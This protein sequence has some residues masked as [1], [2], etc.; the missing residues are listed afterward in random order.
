MKEAR[1]EKQG[2]EKVVIMGEDI[3]CRKKHHDGSVSGLIFIIWGALLLL[4]T[5]NV[6]PWTV[7]NYIWPFWPV[8]LIFWGLQ[9]MFGFARWLIRLIK[10]IVII[11]IGLFAIYQV[12]PTLLSNL[13]PVFYK[14][15]DIMKG[16]QK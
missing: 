4:N 8:I 14:I 12:M 5:L 6:V 9:I 7:W 10:L 13:P 2:E 3:C 15:F 16:I 11:L 1:E